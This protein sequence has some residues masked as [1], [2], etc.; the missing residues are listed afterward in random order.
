MEKWQEREREI[1]GD[2]T[3]GK[4]MG[5]GYVTRNV[6]LQLHKSQLVA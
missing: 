2:T 3:E 4:P 5:K 6:F 1:R